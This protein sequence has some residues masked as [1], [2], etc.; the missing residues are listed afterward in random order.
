MSDSIT[1]DLLLQQE[2]D[3][4][5]THFDFTLAWQL[6]QCLHQRAAEQ[7]APVA[8]EVF[9]FGQ[10]LFF[11]ALPGAGLE[12]SEWAMR[13]RNTVLRNGHASLY[14]GLVNEQKGEPMAAQAFIDQA[15]YTDHGGAFPL[16]NSSGAVLGAVSVS[17][18]PSRE[19]HALALWGI[20]QIRALAV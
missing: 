18:L 14:V 15:R 6:G 7:G 19:D 20:Q 9:A 13:K 5:L 11:S 12:N 17:G 1:P 8:I 4:R 16:L 2:A 3:N 10:V